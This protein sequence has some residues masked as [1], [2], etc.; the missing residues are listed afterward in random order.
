M[1]NRPLTAPR[2]SKLPSEFSAG[3]N[4]LTFPAENGVELLYQLYI[5][6]NFDMAKRY[7]LI[8]YMHSAGVRC[9]DNSHIYTGEAKFL[10][11]LEANAYRDG[12]LVLAPCCP[13]PEK[14]VGVDRWNGL[15]FDAD[16]LPQ[17]RYMAAAIELF[18]DVCANLPVDLARRSLYGM[19]MG[20]FAVW[21]ILARYPHTF[22]AAIV[23]AGC[24]SPKQAAQMTDVALWIFHG[25]ADNAVPFRSA[26]I[27]R[28]AL[29]AAGHPSLKF[30]AFEGAGH[31]I[32]VPTADTEGLYDWL[33]SKKREESE[34][35]A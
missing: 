7:P 29:T 15:E 3:W 30:T 14:W 8:L 33:F 2:A 25:T 31:G 17:T 1:S 4:S 34:A 20:G 35:D 21:D 22:A 9:D 6:Q 12:V 16:T 19:S 26:E 27:M 32:W 23:A 11:N 18:A 24:G 13:R 28:D 10:R 5:P